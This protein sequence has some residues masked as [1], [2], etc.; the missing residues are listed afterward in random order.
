MYEEKLLVKDEH[1]F[2]LLQ[3]YEIIRKCGKEEFV[4]DTIGGKKRKQC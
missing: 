2:F 3:F 4:F 1:F